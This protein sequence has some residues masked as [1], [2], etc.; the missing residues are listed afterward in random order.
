MIGHISNNHPQSILQRKIKMKNQAERLIRAEREEL[1]HQLM[2]LKFK[3]YLERKTGKDFN[4]HISQQ[5]ACVQALIDSLDIPC[6][7][8]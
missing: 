3:D 1:R 7:K 5:L 2:L 6:N 8:S 4:L